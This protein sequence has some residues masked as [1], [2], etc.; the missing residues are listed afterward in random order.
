MPF[1]PQLSFNSYSRT[2]A[3]VPAAPQEVPPPVEVEAA[4]PPPVDQPEPVKENHR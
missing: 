2:A 1:Q 4:K 3:P